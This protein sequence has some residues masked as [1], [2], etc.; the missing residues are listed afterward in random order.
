MSVFYEVIWCIY[1]VVGYMDNLI[2]DLEF[3]YYLG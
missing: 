2:K 1:C 3:N